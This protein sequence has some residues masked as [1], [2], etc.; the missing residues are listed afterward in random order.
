MAWLSAA[1]LVGAAHWGA[2]IPVHTVRHPLP[3]TLYADAQLDRHLRADFAAP[4]TVL[5]AFTSA[6]PEAFDAMIMAIT[7]SSRALI[8]LERDESMA[9]LDEWLSVFSEE[10]RD[11]I[12]ISDVV[13]DTPWV[14]D[15]GPLELQTA[16][17]DTVWLDATYH[18]DRPADDDSPTALAQRL[19]RPLEP[20]TAALEGGALASNGA[21]FC[22][23]TR[24]YF[25]TRELDRLDG[26][27]SAELAA[28][29]GCETVVLVPALASEPTRHVDLLVQFVAEDTV[30]VARVDPAVDASEALRLDNTADALRSA[31]ADEGLVLDVHRIDIPRIDDRRYYTYVN[32]LRLPHAYLVP[33]YKAVPVE[34]EAEIYA[35]LSRAFAG[36]PL[37][38]VPADEMLEL[39]GAVHCATMGLDAE[40]GANDVYPTGLQAF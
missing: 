7:A 13:V 12:Q 34:R 11:K 23:S 22:V 19:G 29:L 3:P 38:P 33:S 39:E 1:V 40:L 24:E 8:V 26:A 30:L 2:P 16:D 31:A 27:A 17:G 10:A 18:D 5:L 20:M 25:A 14:R 32:A 9:E 21:G 36:V 4:R 37:V 15:Y 28:E 35:S 6:W